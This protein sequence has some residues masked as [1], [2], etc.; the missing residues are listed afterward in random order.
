MQSYLKTILIIH[1]KG[2]SL[3]S[4]YYKKEHPHFF[5]TNWDLNPQWCSHSLSTAQTEQ[6]GVQ[7]FVNVYVCKALSLLWEISHKK[8]SNTP[9]RV[10]CVDKQVEYVKGN[11]MLKAFPLWLP[12]FSISYYTTNSFSQ[13]LTNTMHPNHSATVHV[14]VV[15]QQRRWIQ[16]SVTMEEIR[17]VKMSAL[18]CWL[19]I[20]K[21]RHLR[22]LV[23]SETKSNSVLFTL[24]SW[25]IAIDGSW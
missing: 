4:M 20:D 8:H 22:H 2:Y 12:C 21:G 18:Y 11:V 17:Y 10:L 24:S 13:P 6:T 15:S 1:L 9:L 5:F 25:A 16:R 3:L 23:L 7:G 19:T 14:W